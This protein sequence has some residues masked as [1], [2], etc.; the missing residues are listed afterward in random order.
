MPWTQGADGQN[1]QSDILIDLL[2]FSV[3][4][5][6][7][8]KPQIFFFSLS[9]GAHYGANMNWGC[10]FLC[11]ESSHHL[12]FVPVFGFFFVTRD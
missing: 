11:Q 1:F 6:S 8:R 5:S 9:Q 4:F 10:V 3:E 12:F 7:M 2:T